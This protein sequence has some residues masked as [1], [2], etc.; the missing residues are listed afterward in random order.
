MDDMQRAIECSHGQWERASYRHDATKILWF[1]AF[2]RDCGYSTGSFRGKEQLEAAIA[3]ALK[4]TPVVTME[5][6][7]LLECYKDEAPEWA[8]YITADSHGYIRAW[9]KKPKQTP[10]G[11][12]YSAGRDAVL[13]SPGYPP[14][15]LCLLPK[16]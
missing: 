14:G 4:A 9:E 10:G 3:A 16:T 13:V 5:Q 8:S 7:G 2:C 12:Y 15:L 6:N 1:I 11:L